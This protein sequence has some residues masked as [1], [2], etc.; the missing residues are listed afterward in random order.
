MINILGK[1]FFEL[2]SPYRR[3]MDVYG[4][5]QKLCEGIEAEVETWEEDFVDAIRQ[6]FSI[7]DADDD[8]L[9]LQAY[10]RGLS[11][12]QGASVPYLRRF[13]AALPTFREW[14]GNYELLPLAI[15]TATGIVVDIYIP[16][17]DED[18]FIVGDSEVG[19]DTSTICHN[20]KTPPPDYWPN[21][22]DLSERALTAIEGALGEVGE[23]VV[24]EGYIG[25]E[26]LDSGAVNETLPY[27][28]WITLP[29][30]PGDALMTVVRWVVDLLLRAIDIP[31]YTVP[32]L[33]S[34]EEWKIGY[35]RVGVDTL[36]GADDWFEVGTHCVGG[37][38][39]G[40]VPETVLRVILPDGTPEAE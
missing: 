21:A 14:K 39:I 17:Q 25:L 32:E 30:D 27:E 23:F 4:N 29:Y 5:L 8:Q 34:Q 33:D 28:V 38:R 35:S 3:K 40:G 20:Y 12:P 31:V 9:R 19:G 13:L 15:Y 10:H 37:A 36:I 7:S 11:L 26:A 22:G 18:C 24:G 6:A 1:S 16:F 2:L